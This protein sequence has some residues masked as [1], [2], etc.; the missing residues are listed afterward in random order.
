MNGINRNESDAEI[1]VEVLV[2]GNIPAA[3][4]KAHFHVEPPAFAD[5]RNVNVLVEH[6]DVAISFDHAGGDHAGRIR[7]QVNGLR[8]V[9]AELERNLLK[10]QDDVGSV[11]NHAGD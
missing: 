2:G 10:V 8:R 5:G 3:A 1:F 9:A 4:L 6:F 11:F 7:T